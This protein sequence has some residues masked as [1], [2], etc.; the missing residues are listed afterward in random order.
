MDRN[1]FIGI[2]LIFILF[3]VWQYFVTP[4][5]EEIRE[6]KRVEDSIALAQRQA[7]SLAQLG[8]LTA[9]AAAYNPTPADTAR[10]VE[11]DSVAELR[12][13]QDFGPFAPAAKGTAQQIQLENEKI[14]VT[15]SSKGGRVTEVLL[16]E[17]DKV[18]KGSK[19]KETEK[20]P[21]RL[22]ADPKNKFHYFL[23]VSNLPAGGVNT[24]DLYFEIAEQSADGVT[25]RA[26]A[27]AGRYFEQTYHLEQDGYQIDYQIKLEGLNGVLDRSQPKITLNWENYLD[28]LEKNVDIERTYS[29][30][31]YKPVDGN[32]DNCNKQRNDRDVIDNKPLK[33]V[34]HANQ[35]FTS[36]LIAENSFPGGVMETQKLDENSSDLE[37]V[38]STVEIPVAGDNQ[39]TFAMNLYVGPN[40]FDRLRDIG[41]DLQDVVP[42]GWSIFG[43]V[44][45]WIIRPLFS[46]LSSFIGSAGIIILM[47]TLLVKLLLY[48]LTYRMLYS[49]SKMSALK[50]QLEQV[51]SKNKEDQQAQQMETMKLY[52]E[53]GV[54]PLGGC[55]PMLAQMPI[56]IALYRFFPASIE[57]RQASFLWANDLSTYDEFFHLPFDIPYFGAHVSLFT[58]LWALTTLIYTYYNTRHMDMSANPAMKYMQYIMPVMFLGFF[59][60]FASGLTC[61]LLF[62]N[63]LNITQTLV[64]K[65]YIIDQKKIERNLAEYRKKPKKKNTFQQ[66]LEEALKEQKKQQEQQ[67]QKQAKGRKRK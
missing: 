12:L 24:Q 55:L 63:L 59:N 58:L 19:P 28:K 10:E 44:N 20:E 32:I 5:P 41:Y 38:K 29:T 9:D 54:N 40:E 42:F 65:N 30:V 37:L 26:P 35:F 61:Y 27:G 51:R 17:Y 34:A 8:Q 56:W 6:Q 46:W 52:R 49:Q 57:F 16:K 22:L 4:S 48:P 66:R 50:P 67:K 31:Y 60:S 13:S 64:T 47:L 2:A 1:T 45:R 11:S 21:V 62:S 53:N 23:P 33:W 43:T 3:F 25:F 39:E 14:R 7:D 15:L 36:V 18:V